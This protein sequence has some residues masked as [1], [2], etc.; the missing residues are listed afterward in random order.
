MIF[1]LESFFFFIW[2]KGTVMRN[3]TQRTLEFAAEYK[4]VLI[5][6]QTYI[7]VLDEHTCLRI[8]L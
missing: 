2:V 7:S 1:P 8:Q 5:S 3:F 4:L 6:L